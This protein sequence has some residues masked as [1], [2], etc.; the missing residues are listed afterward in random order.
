MDLK[1]AFNAIEE[2]RLSSP[3]DRL[4][5]VGELPMIS[6]F[7]QHD[8]SLITVGEFGAERAYALAVRKGLQY[9]KDPTKSFL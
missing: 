8:C 1:S 3:S 5:F 4:A 9:P 7:K 6:Y 2:V